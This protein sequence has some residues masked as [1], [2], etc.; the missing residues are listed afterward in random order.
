[1]LE[2]KTRRMTPGRGRAALTLLATIGLVACTT[3][4]AGVEPASGRTTIDRAA[5]PVASEADP[6]RVT[7]A[8]TSGYVHVDGIDVYYEVH[9]NGEPLVLLQGAL[10][11]IDIS[12]GALLPTLAE[13]RMVIAIEQQGH[14]RTADRE[15]ALSYERMALDT[16]AVLDHLGVDRTDVF[17]YS[18]GGGVA[19]ELAI[20]HPERVR[21]AIV[22]SMPFQP[23]GWYPGVLEATAHITPDDFIGSG[24]PEA[25]AAVA[26]NP[27]GW[28]TLVEKVKQLDLEFTGWRPKEIRS[29]V[30]PVLVV[31]GDSD[32]VTVPHA[33]QMF[34]LLGGGVAGDFAGLPDSRLAVLAGTTHIGVLLERTDWLLEATSSFLDEAS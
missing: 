20:S 27:D 10:T 19:L 9:G 2:P 6:A 12:F 13:D 31:I 29:I 22:A 11:T 18:M 23:E 8:S 25:Y 30:A 28:S 15:G 32:T 21:R 33:A 24:L 26:P 7:T 5:R 34:E 17:G 3:A 1:M 4:L 16:V 14:G